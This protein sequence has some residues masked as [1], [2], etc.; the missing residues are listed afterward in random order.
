MRAW[1]HESTREQA[2]CYTELPAF[3]SLADAL[4][5]NMQRLPID[6]TRVSPLA[7]RTAQQISQETA[8]Q[9]HHPSP[10]RFRNPRGTSVEL[11]ANNVKAGEDGFDS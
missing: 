7:S 10:R 9:C 1:K 5:G 3:F 4:R 6:A 11:G 2:R 8:R